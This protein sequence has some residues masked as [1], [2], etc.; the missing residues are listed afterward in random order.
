[1]SSYHVFGGTPLRGEV[2]VGGCKNAVLPILF[3]TLLTRGENIFDNVPRISDVQCVLKILHSL[4]VRTSYL[5]LHTLSVDA[6][7]AAFAVPDADAVRHIRASTYLIGSMLARFGRVMLQ[8]FGGCA[9]CERPIDLHLMAAHAFGAKEDANELLTSHL[10]ACHISF[11][12]VSVGATVNALLMAASLSQLSVLS[13]VAIEPHVLALIQ[14]LRMAGADIRISS[15]PK[16]TFFVRGGS[17]HGVRMRMIPDMIEAGTF[18]LAG[19]A[20]GGTVSVRDVDPSHLESLLRALSRGGADIEVHESTVRLSLPACK[21]RMHFVAEPHPGIATDLSP[22]LCALLARIGEGT[23]RDTV[24]PTRKSFLRAYY[25][26]GA[27]YETNDAVIR[28][29][30]PGAPREDSVTIPD[31][32]AGAGAVLF[33]LANATEVTLTDE[34]KYIERGYENFKGKL[35]QLGARIE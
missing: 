27:N 32:R 8:S 5:D 28:F 20:T 1:M 10:C 35:T 18:L 19:A 11:P 7:D 9:F 21:Q 22:L 31:L 16:P 30:T 15:H 23:M 26:L 29:L 24:F 2:A 25:D 34:N 6:T 17:L 14:Y 33:A 3:A 4:G 12:I 13:G